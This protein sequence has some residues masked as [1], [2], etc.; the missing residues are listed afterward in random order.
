MIPFDPSHFIVAVRIDGTAEVLYRAY[1]HDAALFAR[2][3][4]LPGYQLVEVWNAYGQRYNLAVVANRVDL[5]D[6]VWARAATDAARGAIEKYL[7]DSA[8]NDRREELAVHY[9]RRG[10]GAL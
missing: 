4:L 6:R 8:H 9:V 7:A 10:S 5:D 2:Q 3:P 1:R